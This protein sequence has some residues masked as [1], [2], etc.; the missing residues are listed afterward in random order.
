MLA[1]REGVALTYMV[2]D[3]LSVEGEDV[4]KEPYLIRRQILESL[5]L[6][7]ARWRTPV[8]FDDGE[9]LWEA[10]CEHDLEG[11]VA[12]RRLGRYI[13]GNRGWIKSKNRAYWR[14][15]L[16]R[17]VAFNRRRP[18]AAFVRL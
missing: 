17:E 11:V 10:V 9:A 7:G 18:R 8:A 14:Y 3:V 4:T 12:K 1:Q 16:E 15:E 6:E 13:S 2:F 5:C